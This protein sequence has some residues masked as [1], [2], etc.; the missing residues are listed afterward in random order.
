MKSAREESRWWGSVGKISHSFWSN[1]EYRHTSPTLKKKKSLV[2]NLLIGQADNW[3]DEAGN[4]RNVMGKWSAQHVINTSICHHLMNAT[5]IRRICHVS[6]TFSYLATKDQ[7][8]T[9][10]RLP[11][12]CAIF[13]TWSACV[14]ART[15]SNMQLQNCM[16]G[17][18]SA[19]GFSQ[20]YTQDM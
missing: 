15:L 5:L 11:W 10:T 13:H 3:N 2:L 18:R 8:S 1:K 19:T 20:R 16:F 6:K 14:T 12:C 9:F 4:K 17:Q 7:L